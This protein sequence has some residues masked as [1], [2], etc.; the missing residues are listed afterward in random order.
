LGFYQIQRANL[1]ELVV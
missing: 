1:Q